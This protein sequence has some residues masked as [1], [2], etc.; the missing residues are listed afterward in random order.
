[1]SRSLRVAALF[2][3]ER[4]E[5]VTFDHYSARFTVSPA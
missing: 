3:T 5:S 4:A 2:F 1:M